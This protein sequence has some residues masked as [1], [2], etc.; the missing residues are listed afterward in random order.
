MAQLPRS[1]GMSLTFE[2]HLQMS[3]AT[4]DINSGPG[5]V[6]SGT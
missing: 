4:G 3:A 2:H 1:F 5:N 6:K